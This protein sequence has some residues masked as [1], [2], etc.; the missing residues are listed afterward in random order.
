MPPKKRSSAVELA[1]QAVKDE[2]QAKIDAYN[3]DS[4]KRVKVFHL[5]DYVPAEHFKKPSI[6]QSN[7]DRI[8]TLPGNKVKKSDTDNGVYQP[9]P[10]GTIDDAGYAV[11]ILQLMHLTGGNHFTVSY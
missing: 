4:P 10:A 2:K 11:T 5:D 6:A 8:Y 1:K 7:G 3:R 9:V